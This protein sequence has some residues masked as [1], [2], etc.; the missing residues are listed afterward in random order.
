VTVNRFRPETT[1]FL[2]LLMLTLAVWILRGLELLTFI[3]GL[4]IWLL[5]FLTIAAAIIDVLQQTKR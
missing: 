4:V 5:A 2:I 3:P 1:V